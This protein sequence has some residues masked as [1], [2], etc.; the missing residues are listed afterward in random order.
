MTTFDHTQSDLR[1]GRDWT[2]FAPSY[3]FTLIWSLSG[4][5][6]GTY[7]KEFFIGL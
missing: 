5:L 6:A 3:S 1:M 4:H 7:L 2:S